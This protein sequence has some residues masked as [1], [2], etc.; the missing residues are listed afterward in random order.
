MNYWLVVGAKKNWITAFNYK[1]IWGLK[2]TQRH[3]WEH[4]NEDDKAIFYVTSPVSGIIGHGIVKTKFI[5]DKPLWPEEIERN[6][7]IWPLRFDFNITSCLPLEE[8]KSRKLISESIWPRA[9][10]QFLSETIGQD[11]VS[12]LENTQY[13]TPL[14]KTPVVSEGHIQFISKHDKS[15]TAIPSHDELQRKLVEIGSIQGYLT[16]KEYPFDIG[17]LDVVWRRVL[18]SVPTYVFEVQI[19]GD[20]YHALAKLK[21]AFDLWNSHIFLISSKA[22]I[23]K[24]ENLLSGTFHEIKN[25][26]K[27][28]D[29]NKVEE[30]YKR[31]KSYFDFENDLGIV[32]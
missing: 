11:L 19:G 28:I 10:F 6:E 16:Q 21:H 26:I 18:N 30:L 4:L 13:D 12:K 22:D 24:A 31:K 3:L 14:Q 9:G 27:L 32:T 17:R 8:W 20:I 23:D 5:Q 29:L 7:V 1:N 25:R 15:K 2:N